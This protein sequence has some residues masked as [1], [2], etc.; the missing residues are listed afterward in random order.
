M[1][2]VLP[3]LNN[4]NLGKKTVNQLG[5]WSRTIQISQPK[6]GWGGWNRLKQLKL[7]EKH[8]Q[9]GTFSKHK[10][11]NTT[12]S[13]VNYVNITSD[14]TD[15]LVEHTCNW[16]ESWTTES[17]GGKLLDEWENIGIWRLFHG[18][19]LDFPHLNVS[20]HISCLSPFFHLCNFLSR[21]SS[22]MIFFEWIPWR[23]CFEVLRNSPRILRSDSFASPRRSCASKN[24]WFRSAASLMS[25]SSVC[26]S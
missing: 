1:Q 2:L 26:F 21:E 3:G 13:G 6:N 18:W 4:T 24:I 23:I 22:K 15:R 10:R 25:P 11:I 14:S 19:L 7:W 12:M 8:F 5:E 17:L 20:K 9:L 16:P